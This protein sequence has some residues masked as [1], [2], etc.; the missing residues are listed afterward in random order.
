MTIFVFIKRK[1]TCLPRFNLL[2]WPFYKFLYSQ[3]SA[4]L[5]EVKCGRFKLLKQSDSLKSM[6]WGVLHAQ[7]ASFRELLP[8]LQFFFF[9]FL[10][11]QYQCFLEW[12]C[13]TVTWLWFLF[14][15]LFLNTLTS[16]EYILYSK[17]LNIVLITVKNSEVFYLLNNSYFL[18]IIKKTILNGSPWL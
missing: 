6:Q 14:D 5:V 16:W 13:W 15:T 7:N 11:M 18:F 17:T 3:Q 12:S 2:W 9:F 1:L 4:L 8:Q 10:R